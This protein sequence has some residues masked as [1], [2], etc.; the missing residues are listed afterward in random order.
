MNT[1]IQKPL[2]ILLVCTAVVNIVF[3]GWSLSPA[4]NYALQF[5]ITN[6]I[7]SLLLL[8]SVAA[9]IRVLAKRSF[10]L[11]LRRAWG[12]ISSAFLS[13]AIGESL[14]IYY[15]VTLGNV[16]APSPADIFFLLAYP[17]ALAGI[18]SLPYVTISR[19]Q[20][21]LLG[22]DISIV[23][24]ACALF[25]W[26]FIAP[27]LFE[28]ETDG[29]SRLIQIAYILGDLLILCGLASLIQRETKWIRQ[30][31]LNAL[32]GGMFLSATANIMRLILVD[33]SI[34]PTGILGQLALIFFLTERWCFLAAALWQAAESNPE[35]AQA[36]G[37]APLLRTNLVYIAVLCSTGLAIGVLVTILSSNVR[38][39][40][41]LIGSFGITLLVL[42]RQY[43]VLSENQRLKKE[44][45]YLAITDGLTGLYNRRY[46]DQALEG[47]IA[48]ARRH[49]HPLCL[50][51]I[52]VNDFKKYNDHFGHPAGDCLLQE[53]ARL[54]QKSL[55][56]S[57]LIARYG[58]DEF[59][60][61]LPETGLED[62]Q[63]VATKLH[64]VLTTELA[65]KDGVYVS[66]GYA[67]WKPDLTV[68]MLIRLA[69]QAMYQ[70]KP[71]HNEEQK[72]LPTGT[73]PKTRLRI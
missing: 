44:V 39:Y 24:I 34:D 6:V 8:M 29:L 23:L 56:A 55:R 7:D 31:I 41:T 65:A 67:A 27:H 68:D 62:S 57:D 25:L 13:L 15:S 50:M 51:L 52:D 21:R 53:I 14:L 60:I 5:I 17:L 40:V 38:L 4:S 12:L 48:Y 73:I 11:P 58:G 37:F 35:T 22:I 49:E 63:N 47:Q 69:D 3:A 59:V 2:N 45:E 46:F 1:F 70:Q 64:T 36:K 33:A 42:V 54:L 66:I 18:L 28:K 16:P 10:P 19:E 30:R 9:G 72:Y 71:K 61:I 43:F 32:I 20:R 26:Y